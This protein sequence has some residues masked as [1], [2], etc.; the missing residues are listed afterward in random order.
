MNKKSQDNS[1][2]VDNPWLQ[3]IADGTKPVEGRAGPLSKFADWVG[4]PAQF[5]SDGDHPMIVRV[6]VVAV[7]HY[8]NLYDYLAGED[9]QVVAPHLTSLEETIA[10]YHEFYSDEDI[11]RRGGMNAI[12]VVPIMRI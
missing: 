7:R 10:A 9:W 12:A 4:K 11:A 8:D 1:I 2:R 3:L 5:Y 6:I